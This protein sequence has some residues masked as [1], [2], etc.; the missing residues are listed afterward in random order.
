[1]IPVVGKVTTGGACLVGGIAGGFGF[2]WLG[3]TLGQ[4]AGEA[5][6]DFVTDLHWTS[7]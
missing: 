2:G 3:H 1:M 6:Y 5:A 4:W 7:R